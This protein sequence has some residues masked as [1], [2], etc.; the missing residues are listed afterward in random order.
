[1][2]RMTYKAILYLMALALIAGAAFAESVANTSSKA[3]E[4]SFTYQ[5]APTMASNQ[6]AVWIEDADGAMVKTLLVTNFTAG[7]RGYRNR[8][9]SL[10]ADWD[11]SLKDVFSFMEKD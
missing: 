2:K 3:I 7:R 6:M 8:E 5:H 10:P 9:M 11:A 1:M 4:I